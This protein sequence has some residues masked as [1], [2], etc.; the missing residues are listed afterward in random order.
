MGLV[1]VL[2]QWVG[3]GC[4]VAVPF[5]QK[6]LGVLPRYTTVAEVRSPLARVEGEV[7]GRNAHFVFTESTE[8]LA[9][10]LHRNRIAPVLGTY[11]PGSKA[12][13]QPPD[14]SSG[15]HDHR[16]YDI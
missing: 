6:C 8:K 13:R 14:R 4:H 2:K 9:S 15:N 7:G 1:D 5:I 16:N 10:P 11:I 12:R 3:W